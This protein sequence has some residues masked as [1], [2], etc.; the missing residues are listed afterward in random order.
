MF[1]SQFEWMH[2]FLY[3]GKKE[4]DVQNLMDT[5][6]SHFTVKMFPTPDVF[7][8]AHFVLKFLPV[9]PNF[10]RDRAVS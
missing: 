8:Q 5:Y 4:P 6:T 3:E 9:A 7:I 2:F 10:H 1:S